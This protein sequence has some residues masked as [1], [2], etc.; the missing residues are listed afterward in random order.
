M[1]VLLATG[2]AI[3]AMAIGYLVALNWFPAPWPSTAA[4]VV[5]GIA[6]TIGML[7]IARTA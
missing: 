3:E 2:A 7:N 1:K 5:S 6:V 4:V